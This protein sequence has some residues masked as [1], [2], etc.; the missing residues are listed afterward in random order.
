MLELIVS[1]PWLYTCTA[2]IT[3]VSASVHYVTGNATIQLSVAIP[4]VAR[5]LGFV[6]HWFVVYGKTKLTSFFTEPSPS[7]S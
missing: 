3:L 1:K 7:P 2:A 5:I 6:T 4:G